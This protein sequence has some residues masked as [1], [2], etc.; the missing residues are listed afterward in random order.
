MSDTASINV[1]ADCGKLLPNSFIW[2]ADSKMRCH[3]CG[4]PKPT[5]K[6]A[7]ERR[8]AEREAKVAA[9]EKRYGR[10][11]IFDDEQ[12]EFMDDLIDRFV[13]AAERIA[14]AL[15]RSH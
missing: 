9:S 1:C 10:Q 5:P 15:E 3:E 2:G 12:N 11:P 8:R 6:Q 14:D 13:T 7:Y 4:N